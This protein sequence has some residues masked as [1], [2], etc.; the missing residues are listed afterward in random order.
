MPLGA[1]GEHKHEFIKERGFTNSPQM[2]VGKT[3]HEPVLCNK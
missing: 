1:E 2:F 3:S